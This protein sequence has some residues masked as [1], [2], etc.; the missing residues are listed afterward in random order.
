MLIS[1][2]ILYFAR[3]DPLGFSINKELSWSRYIVLDW[4]ITITPRARIIGGQWS[5]DY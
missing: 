3:G 5:C 1:G 2:Q 4:K